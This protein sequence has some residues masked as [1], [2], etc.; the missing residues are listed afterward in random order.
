[1]CIN[2]ISF[3]I[4][5]FFKTCASESENHFASTVI[6]ISGLMILIFLIS[7]FNL[8]FNEKNLKLSLKHLNNLFQ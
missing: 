8:I 3:D 5:F 2:L 7:L 1:M 6:K 4:F